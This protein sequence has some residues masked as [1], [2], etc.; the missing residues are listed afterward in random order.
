MNYFLFLL[1][2]LPLIMEIHTKEIEIEEFQPDPKVK[3][4]D[5]IDYGTM[6]VKKIKK[7][8]FSISGE[9]EIKENFGDERTVRKIL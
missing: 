5:F 8:Q 6:R 3:S 2:L 7:N 9:F 4:D 1:V